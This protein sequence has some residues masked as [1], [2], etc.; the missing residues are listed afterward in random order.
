M[1]GDDEKEVEADLLAFPPQ[2]SNESD[3]EYDGRSAAE[4][5]AAVEVV[6]NFIRI[7][8]IKAKHIYVYTVD[9]RNMDETQQQQ[10]QEQQQSEDGNHQ[11]QSARPTGVAVTDS[12]VRKQ[13]FERAVGRNNGTEEPVDARG[14]VFGGQDYAYSAKALHKA[15]AKDPLAPSITLGVTHVYEPEDPTVGGDLVPC[16]FHV[17]L[18]KQRRYDVKLLLRYCHGDSSVG[19]AYVQGALYALDSIV[20]GC[21]LPGT[22]PI[23][24]EGGAGRQ[25]SAA[26]HPA[27]CDSELPGVSL[28]WEYKYTVRAGRGGL[29]VNVAQRLVPVIVSRTVAD[30]ARDFFA[31]TL[32]TSAADGS[33]ASLGE[34]EWREFEATAKNLRVSA[35]GSAG[36]ACRVV[37]MSTASA[38]Q[39]A[40]DRRPPCLLLKAAD[41]SVC[42]PVS[43]EMAE[44]RGTQVLRPM[45]RWQRARMLA[46]GYLTP[47]QRQ[48]VT[49]HGARALG[50]AQ[51]RALDIFGIRIGVELARVD[52]LVLRPPQLLMKKNKDGD[53]ARVVCNEPP[54]DS[55]KWELAT[56]CAVDARALAS[57]SIVVLGCSKLTM[58]PPLVQ[59]FTMQLVRA[60]CDIGMDVRNTQPS[61]TYA[62]I[63]HAGGIEQ[64]LAESVASPAAASS[65]QLVVCVLPSRSVRVYGELKRVA[66]TVLGVQTQ[67]VVAEHVRAHSPRLMAMVALKINVKLGGATA[68][69]AKRDGPDGLGD[70]GAT[71]VIAA[72]V[73]HTTETQR[74]SVAAVVGSVD[75]QAR[76]FQGIVVQHPARMELIE[77]F[78]V[79]VR[80]CVRLFYKA[81]GIKPRRILYYRD[82][83]SDSQ[84]RAVKDLEVRAIYRG[85][86]LI[87]P[88]YRPAVTVVLARKRHSTRFVVE[89]KKDGV[90]EP[91][92]EF[93]NCLAGTVVSHTVCS[94]VVSS[95]YL[96]AHQ[97][98]LGVTRPTCYLVLHDD[99]AFA[100]HVLRALTYNLC[101]TY[102]IVCRS[103]TMPAALYYAHRLSGKGRL[104]LSSRFDELSYFHTKTQSSTTSK[105]KKP[106]NNTSL[107]PP[108]LVPVHKNIQDSMYFM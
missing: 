37:G 4:Q 14:V 74:M 78:D 90:V 26:A 57:W 53:P 40:G 11:D 50:S 13:V 52:A 80:Q 10:Q 75:S 59:A 49:A 94:P 82:G 65:A 17:T 30:L 1:K 102:P 98:D 34:R 29:L 62:M 22:I 69:L 79:L 45:A 87:D 15:W 25:L 104:Q 67:C 19:D 39:T 76:R 36:C 6:S 97:P 33:L 81:T 56:R 68:E 27:A 103:A 61:V 23:D 66:L 88:D 31:P 64:A 20:R 5:S 72:D 35:K 38:D 9:I 54:R 28:H 47:T 8:Q 60:C 3:S 70:D 2:P 106:R 21:E 95:F 46:L 71:L 89:A 32:R 108:H 44:V 86:R 55:G 96:A 92:A 58:P 16:R 83:V 101:Y 84:L 51:S 48:Q 63:S 99:S 7:E 24:G 93:A 43:L 42:A 91:S 105:N 41:G 73:C 77:N 107:P 18:Q 100:P 85:C 12:Q